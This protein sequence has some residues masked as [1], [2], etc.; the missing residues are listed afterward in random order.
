VLETA[1]MRPK[2]SKVMLVG[3]TTSALKLISA[4]FFMP[5]R[6]NYDAKQVI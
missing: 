1:E 6:G 2:N 3:L 4:P 5:S